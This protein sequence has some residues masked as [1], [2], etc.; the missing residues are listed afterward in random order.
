MK[1]KENIEYTS[2]QALVWP[3]VSGEQ[4]LVVEEK[5]RKNRRKLGL[6]LVNRLSLLFLRV[7]P[8]SNGGGGGWTLDVA[9][10]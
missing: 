5:D 2:S 4:M 10:T 6:W 1:I 3:Q 8:S 7:M 9:G